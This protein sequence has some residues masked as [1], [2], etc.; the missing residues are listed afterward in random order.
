M[1]ALYTIY[2]IYYQFVR[3]YNIIFIHLINILYGLLA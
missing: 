2:I 1:A 3:Y